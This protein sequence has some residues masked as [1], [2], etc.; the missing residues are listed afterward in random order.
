MQE[1][2]LH[3]IPIHKEVIVK[4]NIY[5]YDQKVTQNVHLSRETDACHLRL[6]KDRLVRKIIDLSCKA[7]SLWML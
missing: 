3:L 1:N 6:E 4:V 5:F 2:Y 7:L